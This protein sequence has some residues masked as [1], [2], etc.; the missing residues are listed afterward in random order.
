M[1]IR[2]CRRSGLIFLFLC[3]RLFLDSRCT[4][5]D[6]KENISYDADHIY[7]LDH[8]Y[9]VMMCGARSVQH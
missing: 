3:F 1:S 5:S 9:V 6:G 2:V 4:L 7:H 8:P